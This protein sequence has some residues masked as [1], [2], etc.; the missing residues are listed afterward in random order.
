MFAAP[1]ASLWISAILIARPHMRK[2]GVGYD[3]P[4]PDQ[5]GLALLAALFLAALGFLCHVFLLRNSLSIPDQALNSP[6]VTDARQSVS[7]QVG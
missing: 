3:A 5:S 6:R 1:A 2:G 4:G 7:Q